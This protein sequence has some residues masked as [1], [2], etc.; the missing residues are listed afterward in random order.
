MAF[1][2]RVEDSTKLPN[3]SPIYEMPVIKG[4]LY[5]VDVVANKCKPIYWKG[6]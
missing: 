2:S 5:E 3:T 4:G 1:E 6:R